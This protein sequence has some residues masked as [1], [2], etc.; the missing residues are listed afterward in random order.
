MQWARRVGAAVFNLDVPSASKIARTVQFVPLQYRSEDPLDY[1]RFE[2][3]VDEA[4]AGHL[5]LGEGFLI[6]P[7][8]NPVG[9]GRRRAG[10]QAEGDIGREVPVLRTLSREDLRLHF[11]EAKLFE[12]L[13]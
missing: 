6:E 9:S 13:P 1:L 3:E 10:L 8:D 12:G 2:K 4:W 11:A 5:N 7:G